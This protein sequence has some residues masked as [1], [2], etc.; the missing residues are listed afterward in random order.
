MRTIRLSEISKR[1]PAA[2]KARRQ[3]SAAAQPAIIELG[4]MFAELWE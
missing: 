1:L 2:W 4:G 3:A